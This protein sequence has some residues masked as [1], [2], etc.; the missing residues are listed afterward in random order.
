MAGPSYLWTSWHSFRHKL[1]TRCSYRP[2]APA[3]V[4]AAA[5]GLGSQPPHRAL[6]APLPLLLVRRAPAS[7]SLLATALHGGVLLPGAPS[8]ASLP[9]ALSPPI[10]RALR[11]FVSPSPQA[12]VPSSQQSP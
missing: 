1:G 8:R 4:P 12:R 3:E 5:R 10:S 9:P 7:E 11:G 6:A 2:P